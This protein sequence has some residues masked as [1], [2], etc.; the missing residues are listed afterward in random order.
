MSLQDFTIYDPQNQ[1]RTYKRPYIGPLGRYVD[2]HRTEPIMDFFHPV[3]GVIITNQTSDNLGYMRAAYETITSGEAKHS[4]LI[5]TD[6]KYR[7]AF[8]IFG[9]CYHGLRCCAV[10][11]SAIQIVFDFDEDMVAWIFDALDEI[12]GE[13]EAYEKF[14]APRADCY[15]IGW[16]NVN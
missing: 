9:V 8:T 3:R 14:H 11:D 15:A 10:P 6:R 12:Y 1:T 13:D 4:E 7:E 16:Q 5:S 2:A